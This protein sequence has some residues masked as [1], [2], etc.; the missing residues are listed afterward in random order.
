MCLT[1]QCNSIRIVVGKTLALLK[2]SEKKPAVFFE[3]LAETTY[4]IFLQCQVHACDFSLCN[5]KPVR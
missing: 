4:S 1:K 3:T 2:N 5:T